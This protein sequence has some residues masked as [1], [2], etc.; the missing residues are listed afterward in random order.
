MMAAVLLAFD[1]R[2]VGDQ[3]VLAAGVQHG[4][5]AGRVQTGGEHPGSRRPHLV[6]QRAEFAHDL[7]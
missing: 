1:V 7:V 3:Y 4:R 2:A 6:V 5:G